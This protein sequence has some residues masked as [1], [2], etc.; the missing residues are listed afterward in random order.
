MPFDKILVRGPYVA[1]TH[2]DDVD[3][4]RRLGPLHQSTM[5][6]AQVALEPAK[7]VAAVL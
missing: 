6:R 2:F 1:T 7:A 4:G 5:E 3:A